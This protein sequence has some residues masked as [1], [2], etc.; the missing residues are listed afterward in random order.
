MKRVLQQT[1]W[2]AWDWDFPMESGQSAGHSK[3]AERE[4]E[5][6][7]AEISPLRLWEPDRCHRFNLENKFAM[8]VANI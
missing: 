5:R 1:D 4:R 6:C 3:I 8:N 2:M 7:E